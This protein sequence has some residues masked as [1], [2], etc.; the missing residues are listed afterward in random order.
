[1]ILLWGLPH[2]RPLAAVRTALEKLDQRVIMLDQGEVLA[3][4]LEMC[5][6]STISGVVR[7]GCQSFRLEDVRA[8]YLR[9][10]DISRFPALA[11]SGPQSRECVHAASFTEALWTWAD[12]APAFVVNR[13]AA[14]LANCSKPYQA[15][16]IAAFGFCYTRHFDHERCQG[17]AC[18]LEPAGHG[19]LQIHWRSAQHRL[20]PGA[21]P[22]ASL[23]ASSLVPHS[24]PG[25]HRGQ[26][27]SRPRDRR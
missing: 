11:A 12:L 25:V 18:V 1:M 21:S 15:A 16:Q 14:M 8:A 20:A 13:P 7:Q 19:H 23:A 22:C 6:G 26:G 17:C 4:E 27:L 3:A 9:P 24:V 5:V 10:Y 2:E